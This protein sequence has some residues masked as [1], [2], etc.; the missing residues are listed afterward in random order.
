MTRHADVIL[1]WSYLPQHGRS[2]ADDLS[3]GL[4]TPNK[5]EPI[6]FEHLVQNGCV[7]RV[8][9]RI[10]LHTECSE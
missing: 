2:L 9:A 5:Y 10:D 1:G 6:P 3:L 4:Q 8:P 7:G